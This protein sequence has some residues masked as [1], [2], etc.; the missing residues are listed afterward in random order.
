MLWSRDLVSSTRRDLVLQD[1]RGGRLE[2]VADLQRAAGRVVGSAQ[3][4]DDRHA[5]RELQPTPLLGGGHSGRD[6]FGEVIQL[7]PHVLQAGVDA[8]GAG[9][10]LDD[11]RA[12][13]DGDW[14]IGHRS[15][16]RLPVGEV[17]PRPAHDL[18]VVAEAQPIANLGRGRAGSD[19]QLVDVGREAGLLRLDAERREAGL[20]VA[21]GEP[22]RGEPTDL[23]WLSD[24][25]ALAVLGDDPALVAQLLHRLPDRHP[26]YAVVLDQLRLARQL[27]A[28]HE[29]AAVDQTTELIGNLSVRR[30]VARAVD[31]PELHNSSRRLNL[32]DRCRTLPNVSNRQEATVVDTPKHSV[33]VAGIVVDDQDRVLVIQRRDNGHWEPPG[34]VLELDETPEE[35]VKREVLE[36]TGLVVTVEHLSGV[37]KN[38]SLKIIALVF[39]CRPARGTLRTSD[40]SAVVRWVSAEEVDSLMAPAY[41]V[42]VTDARVPHASVRVHDGTRVLP[43]EANFSAS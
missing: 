9:V 28:G 24:E 26:G 36:E 32:Y 25:R 27:V 10:G 21:P 39:K 38:M 1:V 22:L 14:E 37:Y 35:G 43:H 31:G 18:F 16:D 17:A 34:G 30:P 42:R 33:S 7:E 13:G 4:D 29:A 11:A 41:A 15:L 19:L 2:G 23:D 40:E 3:E 20:T 12:G 8:A 5:V 6:L